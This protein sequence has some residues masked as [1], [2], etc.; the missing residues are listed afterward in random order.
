MNED[1]KEEARRIFRAAVPANGNVK[2]NKK[3]VR[4]I[5]KALSIGLACLSL[6]SAVF[7][8]FAFPKAKPKEVTQSQSVQQLDRSMIRA[9]NH[10]PLLNWHDLLPEQRVD[11]RANILIYFPQILGRPNPNKWMAVNEW[12]QRTYGIKYIN[13]RDLFGNRRTDIAPHRFDVLVTHIDDIAWTIMYDTEAQYL[14]P[15][16][17]TIV[18]NNRLERYS[19]WKN[20]VRGYS[21]ENFGQEWTNYIMAKLG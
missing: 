2:A 17:K 9:V 1:I 20:L 11:I 21:E 13:E 4:N 19:Q 3:P 15:Y 5:Y 16:W 6:V 18:S 12:L 7:F 8:Y 14:S 10:S